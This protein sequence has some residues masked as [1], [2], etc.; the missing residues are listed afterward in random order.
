MNAKQWLKLYEQTYNDVRKTISGK[1]KGSAGKQFAELYGNTASQIVTNQMQAEAQRKES[2][3]SYQRS[4]APNQVALMQSAGMSRAGAINALNGGGSYTPATISPTAPQPGT[5][6]N[7]AMQLQLEQLNN[8]LD[9]L[10]QFGSQISNVAQIK[11]QED[12]LKEQ[13]RQF[14]L[15]LAENKRQFDDNSRETKRVNDATIAKI[16]QSLKIEGL[17]EKLLTIEYNL[18]KA[19]E[20]GELTAREKEILARETSAILESFKQQRIIDALNNVPQEDIEAIFELQ[21]IMSLIQQGVNYDAPKALI[22]LGKKGVKLI[23]KYL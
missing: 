17:Q 7:N 9:S 8:V 3:L 18:Q 4:S 14:D 11:H 15:T 5:D 2:E 6:A 12:Q 23:S 20:S 22:E 16:E 19:T 21:A 10:N 1:T 13:K